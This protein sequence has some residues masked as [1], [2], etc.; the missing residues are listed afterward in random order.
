VTV[1]AGLAKA[2]CSEA[3]CGKPA[4]DEEFSGPMLPLELEVEAFFMTS[5]SHTLAF[6]LRPGLGVAW[7]GDSLGEKRRVVL[8][9]GAA[10]KWL[11]SLR[12]AAYPGLPST[13][14]GTT[15]GFELPFGVFHD[16]VDGFETGWF[17]G[18]GFSAATTQ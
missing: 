4:V 18:L 5:P 6:A 14:R 17:I 15:A 3:L 12:T 1:A 2:Y 8:M 7:L 9:P 16:P 13:P 10:F 11:V